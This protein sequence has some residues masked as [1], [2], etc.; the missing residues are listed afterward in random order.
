MSGCGQRM[1]NVFVMTTC[2]DSILGYVPHMCTEMMQHDGAV[3]LRSACEVGGQSCT[4]CYVLLVCSRE[5]MCVV[6]E[7][8]QRWL[9]P[10]VT[11]ESL[12][13]VLQKQAPPTTDRYI[14]GPQQYMENGGSR[15]FDSQLADIQV[16]EV[17]YYLRGE[18]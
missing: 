1:Y 8:L 18:L 4:C 17:S 9:G 13:R 2:F 14:R 6:P 5:R 12:A 7:L 16:S 15:C 3:V 11:R 10:P